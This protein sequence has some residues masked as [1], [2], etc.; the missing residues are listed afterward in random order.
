MR[1]RDES[2]DS[3][4]AMRLYGSGK[5]SIGKSSA[6]SSA[7]G[8]DQSSNIGGSSGGGSIDDSLITVTGH[9]LTVSCMRKSNLGRINLS[10]FSC[11]VKRWSSP[12]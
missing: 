5:S 4:T 10:P 7:E 3:R 12:V 1:Y 2:A 11:E 8:S 6:T 9:E